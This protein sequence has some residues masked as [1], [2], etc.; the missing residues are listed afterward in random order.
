MVFLI[1]GESVKV[2]FIRNSITI[3]SFKSSFT[4]LAI[5]YKL[6]KQVNFNSS[7][8]ITALH[9]IEDRVLP[10]CLRDDLINDIIIYI[11]IIA[12]FGLTI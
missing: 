5:I 4:E 2:E 9:F 10:F 1:V 3:V 8:S 6:S 11:N 12:K 7:T